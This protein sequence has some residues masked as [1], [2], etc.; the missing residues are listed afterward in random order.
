[1]YLKIVPVVTIWDGWGD[2]H[3]VVELPDGG[4]AR[5]P[6]AWADESLSVPQIVAP[7]ERKLSVA[8]ARELVALLGSLRERTRG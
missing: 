7:S 3:L 1:L 5:I 8:S 4:H 2:R 6:C